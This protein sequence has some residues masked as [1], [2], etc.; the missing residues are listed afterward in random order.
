MLVTIEIRW[1]EFVIYHIMSLVTL[2]ILPVAE[3]EKD[4]TWVRIQYFIMVLS[5]L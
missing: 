5:D 3:A 2:E 1:K 4:T